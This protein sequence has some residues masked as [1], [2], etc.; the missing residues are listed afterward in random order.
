MTPMTP[1]LILFL[2]QGG[3]GAV[4]TLAHHELS[5]ALPGRPGARRELALHA[6]REAIYAEVFLGLAWFEW[7]GAWAIGLMALMLGE[8]GITLADFIEEDRTRR[9]P[10]SERVLHTLMAIGFGAILALL[11]PIALAWS[12]APTA[13]VLAPHGLLSWAMSVVGLGAL[14][15]AARD[16]IAAAARP[17][18][19]PPV[20]EALTPRGGAVLVTGATGFIGRA[21]VAALARQGRRVL[22][23]SRDALAAR[24]QFRDA[25]FRDAQLGGAQIG[26]AQIGGA[27][28]VVERLD[29]LPAELRL[30]GVVNLA[31]AATVGG[32]WTRRRQRVLLESRRR[33]TAALVALFERLETPPPVLVSGSATGFY[34][35]A[36]EAL[37]D[38]TSPP[39]DGRFLSDLCRLW[40]AETFKARALGV[41]VCALRLGMVFDWSGGPLP[42]MALP[43]RF[44]LAAMLGSG[45]Q[46]APWIHRRDAVR[47]ILT[48]L[49]DPAWRGAINAVAPD[50][51]TNA[52]FTRRLARWLGRPAWLNVPAGPLRL[53]LGPLADLFLASQR[54]LPNKAW[55]LGFSFERPTLE[56][57]FGPRRA[58]APD[59]ELIRLTERPPVTARPSPP[60]LSPRG[61]EG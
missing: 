24:A 39:E 9:L 55:A 12:R 17:R 11:A 48:A 61:G 16:G 32:L 3:L 60:S 10:P 23:L 38:E 33:T 25:Q 22:V 43:A 44:G 30:A 19:E 14:A 8:V 35:D 2:I 46:W 36:G 13:V 6:A 27:V 58:A 41:R 47:M 54:V 1:L 21:L 34:G 45:R 28:T 42:L 49:D 57:A 15:W 31:G 37:L 26:G 4:D 18:P 59:R 56:M 20:R 29:D 51:V 40:E 50:L 52:Q 7:R 53:A 5:A